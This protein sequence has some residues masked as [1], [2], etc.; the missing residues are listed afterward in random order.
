MLA[1]LKVLYRL[2]N[3]KAIRTILLII[4]LPIIALRLLGILQWMELAA[5]DLLF[6]FSPNEPKEERIVLVTWD[7]QDLQGT[8]HITLSDQELILVLEKIKA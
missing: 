2:I 5:Y 7:E 8:Q 3:K 4:I 1:R 6:Y